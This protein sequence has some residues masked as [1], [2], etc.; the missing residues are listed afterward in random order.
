MS[1]RIAFASSAIIATVLVSISSAWA[2]APSALDSA[3]RLEAPVRILSASWGANIGGSCP[4]GGTGFDIL[5]ITFS[6]F[7]RPTS[8]Q[9]E[10]FTITRDDGTTTHPTCA[11][12]YPPDERNEHQTINMM[13]EFGDPAGPRP[14][15]VTVGGGLQ[16]RAPGELRWH[17]VPAGLTR[18]INQ[19]EEGPY[20]A[21]AWMLTPRLLKGDKN[22]CT[23]GKN[24]VRVTWSNGMTAYPTGGEVDAAVVNS[25]R[26]VFTLP[27]GKSLIVKPLAVGDLID[28]KVPA[29]DDNMHDLCLP[30][31]PAGA[32]L[33]EVR[34]GA[35]FLQD[36][37]GDPNLVQHYKVR[38]R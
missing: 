26:A 36:P 18:S 1:R 5:P 20:I 21:D 16:S 6:A 9:P 7:I 34:I 15:S 31:L 32:T 35:S 23:V 14:I 28:H 33:S 12:M 3:Q 30:A 25:Y 22:A 17:D 10:D 37:N 2:A 27:T 29:N 24:F 8:F 11:L 19:L 38:R 4:T 13:G